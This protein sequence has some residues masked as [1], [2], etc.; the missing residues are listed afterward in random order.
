MLTQEIEQ[1]LDHEAVINDQPHTHAAWSVGDVAH[2]GD[3]IFIGLPSMPTGAKVRKNRQL[4]DGTTQGSRHILVGGKCYDADASK[5]ADAIRAA[6]KRVV[7]D[8]YIGPVFR[9]PCQVTHPEH[10][11]HAWPDD[12]VVAVVYQRNLDSEQREQ[13]A[14]D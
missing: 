2:Q 1:L 14:V 11:D 12:C 3:L 8:K 13:M 7:T 9:G 4:A 10:G 5:V 6:T